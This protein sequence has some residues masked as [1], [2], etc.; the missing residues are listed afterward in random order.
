M[1]EADSQF[2]KENKVQIPWVEEH[3]TK[4]SKTKGLGTF[5]ID[6]K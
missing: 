5:K 2:I 6:A 3:K 4:P 1:Q